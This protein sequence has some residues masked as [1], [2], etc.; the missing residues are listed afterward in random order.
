MKESYHKTENAE[1]EN[2]FYKKKINK[3][4]PSMYQGTYF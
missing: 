2:S 3:Q 1:I 4:I